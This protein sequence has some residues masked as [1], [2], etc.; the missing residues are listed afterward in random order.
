MTQKPPCIKS[1]KLPRSLKK[2]SFETCFTTQKEAGN[3]FQAPFVFHSLLHNKTLDAKEKIKL[4]FLGFLI[5]LF[6][7]ILFSKVFCMQW[8]FKE[9]SGN[10]FWCTFSPYF[11]HKY[12]PYLIFYQLIKFQYQ[13]FFL[14]QNIKQYVFFIINF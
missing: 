3:Q 1:S 10:S 5:I 9:G 11:F 7:N 2:E 12:A 4:T 14:S 13:T 6:Q 8:L